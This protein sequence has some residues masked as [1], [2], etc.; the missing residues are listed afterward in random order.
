MNLWE[1]WEE[2]G[3]FFFVEESNLQVSDEELEQLFRLCRQNGIHIILH[4]FSLTERKYL[5]IEE[6]Q[7]PGSAD[8]AATYVNYSLKWVDSVEC[9]VKLTRFFA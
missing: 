6:F 8:D 5:Y 7:Y 9:Q 1:W 4:G 2:K 3:T